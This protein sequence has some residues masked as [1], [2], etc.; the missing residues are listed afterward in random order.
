MACTYCF[1]QVLFASFPNDY[2]SD[3]CRKINQLYD[4]GKTVPE[5]QKCLNISRASVQAFLPYKK[6]VYNAKKLSLNAALSGQPEFLIQYLSFL[7]IQEDMEAVPV[8]Q[9]FH[10]R[11]FPFQCFYVI[12]GLK[13]PGDR[14]TPL[15]AETGHFLRS[16]NRRFPTKGDHLCHA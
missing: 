13:K 1:L 15:Q 3:I 9:I 7:V 4:S 12:C 8:C 16:E 6:C 11:L 10:D 14:E 2:S 5:I